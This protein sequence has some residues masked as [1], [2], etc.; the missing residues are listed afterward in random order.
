MTAS[1]RND[2]NYAA[3]V[4]YWAV[5][6]TSQPGAYQWIALPGM[7]LGND[8]GG[9]ASKL[10]WMA[11]YGCQSL[12]ERDFNDLWW[13]FLL[14]M[15]PNLRLILGAEDRTWVCGLFGSR[16][17]YN[18]NGWTTPQSGPMTI[19]D[20]WCDAAK[21]A[22]IAQSRSG[23]NRILMQYSTRRVSVV[24]R[25]T[26]QGG[27]WQTISDKIWGWGGDISYDWF[28]VSLRELQ[29]YPP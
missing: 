6:N 5:Y 18:L 21:L 28:D 27:S 10:K 22:Y 19:F 25:D 4:P 2:P 17:A 29:V 1:A 12:K 26:T 14:P 3:T 11:F 24:Y 9:T 20:A 23:W 8:Y 15:P 16:F 7:D 13:S